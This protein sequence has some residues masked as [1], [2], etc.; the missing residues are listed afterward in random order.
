[1]GVIFFLSA[2]PTLP[3]LPHVEP[4]GLA[5]P[6]GKVA[7]VAVYAVLAALLALGLAADRKPGWRAFLLAFVGAT[8]YGVTDELHQS[9][10]P[11]RTPAWTD[12]ALDSAGAALGA[13]GIALLALLARWWDRGR[14]R[15]RPA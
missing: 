4:G 10:V 13:A 7:H 11:S 15:G 8:L 2:Q 1:M 12:V 6:P 9:F 14:T 3:D 5:L